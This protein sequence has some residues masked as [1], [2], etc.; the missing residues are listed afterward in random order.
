MSKVCSKCGKG[1]MVGRNVSHSNRKT[2]RTFE[3]NLQKVNVTQ[4]GS[5]QKQYVC[6]KCLKTSKKDK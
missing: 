6:A 2:S 1:K 4:Q 3:V 5:T